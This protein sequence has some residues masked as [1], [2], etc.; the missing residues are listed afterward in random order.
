MLRD[1]ITLLAH[2]AA[3]AGVKVEHEIFEV[4]KILFFE[5]P[6][7]EEILTIK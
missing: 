2:K 5:S 4:S 7:L 3:M 6:P 1:E